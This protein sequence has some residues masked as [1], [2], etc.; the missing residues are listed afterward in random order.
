MAKAATVPSFASH[1]HYYDPNF[2]A[3]ITAKMQVPKRIKVAGNIDDDE[4]EIA[5][6]LPWQPEKIDMR[7]PDR[8]LVAGQDRHI[9]T[10]APPRELIIE[11][12]VM[13]PDPGLIR[14][15][16]PPRVITLDEHYFPSATDDYYDRENNGGI[17]EISYSRKN[18]YNDDVL[19]ETSQNNFLN[20]TVNQSDFTAVARSNGPFLR[21]EEEV[22]HL[23][24]QLVKLNRRVMNIERELVYNQQRD[25]ALLGIGAV[26][27]LIKF[28]MWMNRSS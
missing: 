13:P 23:R 1:D 6:K 15:Q 14:I 16:T 26:Y 2:T 19:L 12:T 24:K 7:V 17:N 5:P 9:G 4:E 21:T 27:V 22:V 8:I 18:D 28:F 25:K 3:E 20:D 10:P 11:N